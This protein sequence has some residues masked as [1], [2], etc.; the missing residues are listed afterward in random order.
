MH[1]QWLAQDVAFWLNINQAKWLCLH[2]HTS[3]TEAWMHDPHW[4]LYKAGTLI[5]KHT[6]IYTL[7]I[8]FVV[9]KCYEQQSNIQIGRQV[10]NPTTLLHILICFLTTQS[11]LAERKWCHLTENHC[12]A[13][14]RLLGNCNWTGIAMQ[15]NSCPHNWTI[16]I[17]KCHYFGYIHLYK[18][19]STSQHILY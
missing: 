8:A 14:L 10:K 3:R 4:H 19:S 1:V 15:H 13:L 17:L 12:I 16:K 2:V 5:T 18:G 11:S 7:I 6:H 9:L